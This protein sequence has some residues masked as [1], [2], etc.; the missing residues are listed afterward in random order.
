MLRDA[1][2]SPPSH[3]SC[4]QKRLIRKQKPSEF[5]FTSP[6][7]K[8]RTRPMPVFSPAGELF[9]HPRP[10][11]SLTSSL[12]FLPSFLFRKD[13]LDRMQPPPPA[14][15]LLFP[16]ENPKCQKPLLF[17]RNLAFGSLSARRRNPLPTFGLSPPTLFFHE[18]PTSLFVPVYT[19]LPPHWKSTPNGPR[20]LYPPWPLL[21]GFGHA[22]MEFF[23]EPL[24]PNRL[25]GSF[26]EAF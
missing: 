2:V 25:R 19:F 7:G 10:F 20:S 12:R 24:F 4:G 13:F 3:F 18:V 22:R 5:S 14:H 15:P 8:L 6:S 17:H 21:F 26:F 1:G 16:Q 23:S 11:F 9:S